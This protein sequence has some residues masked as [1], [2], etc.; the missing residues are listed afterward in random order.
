MESTTVADLDRILKLLAGIDGRL[1][2]LE[3]VL[4]RYEPLL[5][6]AAARMAGPLRWQKKER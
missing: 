3:A 5:D 4:A 1:A 6:L 2:R